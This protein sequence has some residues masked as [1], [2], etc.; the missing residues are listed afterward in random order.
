MDE[1]LHAMSGTLLAGYALNRYTALEG[2]YTRGWTRVRYTHAG[3]TRSL[4]SHYDDLSLYLKLSYPIGR[5]SPYLLVGYGRS[6][7][8]DLGGRDREEYGVHYGAGLAWHLD[9]ETA[10]FGEYTRLYHG[11]GFG[12]QARRDLLTLDALT[13]GLRYRF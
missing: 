6:T 7:L 8:S 9:D 2:R 1:R 12:G 4:S 3:A 5:W 11:Y 10:L 13:V